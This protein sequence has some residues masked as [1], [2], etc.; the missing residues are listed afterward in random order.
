MREIEKVEGS[1]ITKLLDYIIGRGPGEEKNSEL[2][3]LIDANDVLLTIL[4]SQ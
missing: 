1:S 2:A 4:R 3:N